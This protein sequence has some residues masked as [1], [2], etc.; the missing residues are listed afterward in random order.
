MIDIQAI[1]DWERKTHTGAF[2]G[3]IPSVKACKYILGL[4]DEVDRRQGNWVELKKKLQHW[5]SE[6]E[7]E[8]AS[9]ALGFILKHV[10]PGIEK[11]KP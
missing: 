7:D 1:R 8:A 2:T 9:V 6:E 4:C 3:S 5:E 11:G 10:M